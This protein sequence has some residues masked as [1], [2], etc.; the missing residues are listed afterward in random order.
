MTGRRARLLLAAL[1]VASATS[2]CAGIPSSGAVHVVEV[3]STPDIVPQLFSPPPPQPGA[4]PVQV[5]SGF[6]D[7]MQAFPVSTDVAAQYLTTDAAGSW[8]PARR[9]VVYQAPRLSE[10]P[11][12]V[13]DMT[14]LQSAQL[15]AQGAFRPVPQERSHATLGWRLQR[16]DGQWRITNPPDALYVD[17]AYFERYYQ[18]YSLFYFDPSNQVLIPDP[19]YQPLGEQ[20]ATTLVRALLAGP[21]P[22][23]APHLR[24]TVPSS[25][26]LDVAIP[27]DPAGVAD[28]RLT[29]RL[30]SLSSTQRELMSAQLV[31][32]LRQ[33]TG[34]QGVR[35]LVNGQSLEVRGVTDVQDIHLWDVYNPTAGLVA[36][37]L[38]ALVRGR[39]VLVDGVSVASVPGVLGRSAQDL[40]SI[41]VQEATQRL[42]GVS[43]DGHR[44]LTGALT[45]DSAKTLSPLYTAGTDLSAPL[46]SGAGSVWTV[47]RRRTGSRLVVVDDAAQAPMARVI[48]MGRLGGERVERFTVS[49]DG[50]RFVALVRPLRGH[51]P[52]HIEIGWVRY[53]ADGVHVVGLSGISELAV[54]GQQF[55]DLLDVGWIDETTIGVLGRLGDAPVEVYSVSIDGSQLSGGQLSGDPLP[56]TFEAVSLTTSGLSG[57]PLYVSTGDGSLYSYQDGQWL[58]VGDAAVRSPAF[59]G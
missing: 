22:G 2:G 34:V 52:A 30:D 8:D 31:S 55:N 58:R 10:E 14:S 39:I 33:V 45:P 16:Q 9:T 18:S 17:V 3:G 40:R 42:V 47:D 13:V 24:T 6:L 12:G 54:S 50:V 4:T 27:V 5:V 44:L 38:Y 23:T 56:G 49:S 59:A 1:V 15:S 21:T 32:T 43:S 36:R 37:Q 11:G 53:A 35:I 41:S 48:A 20:L 7:A 57:S 28:V 46:T 26:R 19:V 29:G 25:A 51:G